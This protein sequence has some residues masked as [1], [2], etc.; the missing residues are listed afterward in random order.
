V[1]AISQPILS[2]DQP[3]AGGWGQTSAKRICT[4]GAILSFALSIVTFGLLPLWI[5]SR[6][7]ARFSSAERQEL[8]QLAIWWRQRVSPM[9][10]NRIDAAVRQLRWGSSLTIV[11]LIVLA[12][13]GSSIVWLL[14]QGFSVE[15]VLEMT[16]HD[17]WMFFWWNGSRVSLEPR[18]FWMTA[19]LLGYACQW[20]AVRSHTMAVDSLAAAIGGASLPT[21]TRSGLNV[22]WIAA[23]IVFCGMR[24]WWGIPLVLAGAMQRRYVQVNGPRMRTALAEQAR[25]I[26]SPMRICRTYRCSTH[27]AA[28]ANFCPRCGTAVRSE[29]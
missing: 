5:W 9:Q 21:V 26:A 10:V 18:A 27:L 19:L 16:Y 25:Q 28:G 8:T 2:P 13:V 29:A 11:P 22:L 20:M 7:W 15:Q 17:R 14:F 4:S 3:A 12:A 1:T 24:A 6:R 23:L